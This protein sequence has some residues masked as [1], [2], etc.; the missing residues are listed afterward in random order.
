[1]PAMGYDNN[2]YSQKY[3]QNG[4]KLY[5]RHLDNVSG[6]LTPLYSEN[7]AIWE[8]NTIVQLGQLMGSSALPKKISINAYPRNKIGY[9]TLL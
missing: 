3:A 6:Q 9:E 5:F 4:D 7:P 1:M 8:N 2:P